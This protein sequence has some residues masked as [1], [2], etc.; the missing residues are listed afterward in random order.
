M[1]D[2][3]LVERDGKQLVESPTIAGE[4]GI[5]HESMMKII[6][7]Y[8]EAI[9]A[10]FGELRFEIG[11]RSDGRMNA[12]RPR[13]AL[14]TEDQAIFVATLSK[15]TDKVVLF[16]T[17]LVKAYSIARRAAKS[18]MN[19]DHK[20]VRDLLSYNL[21]LLDEM[22]ATNKELSAANQSISILTPLAA[23]ATDLIDIKESSILLREAGPMFNLGRNTFYEVL[24][25]IGIL[26][27]YSNYP[28]QIYFNKGYFVKKAKGDLLP[29]GT[30]AAAD[31]A[32]ITTL[33]L[34]FLHGLGI[35]NNKDIE[36][37]ELPNINNIKKC[38]ENKSEDLMNFTLEDIDISDIINKNIK[39]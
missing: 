4:L 38:I 18:L 10:S 21:K 14:L 34:D 36:L 31:V 7:T 6:E 8:K 35:F 1:N 23:F 24:R 27:K 32:I 15:N 12:P 16:K 26:K 37:L 17:R 22:E 33:G 19:M 3:K 39:D 11:V 28:K 25:K 9:E 20:D 5:Q 29:D 13:I 30:K 2:L